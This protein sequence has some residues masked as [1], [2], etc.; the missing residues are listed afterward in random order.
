M[1]LS[2]KP[3]ILEAAIEQSDDAVATTTAELDP[4]S[5]VFVHVDD[6]FTRMTGY[7]REELLGATPRMLQRPATDRG[8]LDRLMTNLRVG[9]LTENRR[10]VSRNA[11][12]NLPHARLQ[13]CLDT[14]YFS[15]NRSCR[16]VRP[17]ETGLFGLPHHTMVTQESCMNAERA[18]IFVVGLAPL[19]RQL[20]RNTRNGD[21]DPFHELL[22][23]DEIAGARRFDMTEA[24]TVLTSSGTEF[25][26]TAD[27]HA[28]EGDRRVFCRSWDVTIPSDVV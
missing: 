6:A 20:L 24:H 7:P 14:G 28:H 3:R 22:N 19:N 26:I 23:H 21:N 1:A 27:P 17:Q 16:G 18:N 12:S 5:P 9:R 13:D 11:S 8:V 4:P 10:D 2:D 25:H 15:R